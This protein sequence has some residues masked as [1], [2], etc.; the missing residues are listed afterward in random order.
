MCGAHRA[1][2]GTARVFWGP[3]H[4]NR[5]AHERNKFKGDAVRCELPKKKQQKSFCLL[6]SWL[7][8]FFPESHSLGNTRLRKPVAKPIRKNTL[9]PGCSA[10]KALSNNGALSVS[11]TPPHTSSVPSI[12]SPPPPPPVSQPG[13]GHSITATRVASRRAT[14]HRPLQNKCQHTGVEHT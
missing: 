5:S 6:L 8:L 1:T 12:P 10:S 13:F 14:S 4:G 11:H 3:R 7:G 9:S 2:S